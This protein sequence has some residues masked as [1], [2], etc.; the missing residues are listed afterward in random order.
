M[1][2]YIEKN[3][4]SVYSDS[5]QLVYS[6]PIKTHK[7]YIYF[8]TNINKKFVDLL[9]KSAPSGSVL[10]CDYDHSFVNFGFKNPQICPSGI[11]LYLEQQDQDDND[12]EHIMREY[13]FLATQ[14]S[15]DHCEIILKIKERAL[16]KLKRII[17]EN[18]DE[19]KEIFGSFKIVEN[20][21][22]NGN[23]VHTLDIIDS[24]LKSGSTDD[25][26]ASPTV[27][28]F[29]THPVS[30]YKMYKVKYGPPSVQDY[31]SI[32]TLCKKHN[33]VVHFVAS[34]EGIYVVYLLPSVNGAEKTIINKIEKHF[35]YNDKKMDLYKYIDQINALNIFSVSLRPWKDTDLREGLRIHFRKS[36]EW[37]NCKIRD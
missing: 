35:K 29:H 21:K 25:V 3:I 4:F 18:N 1:R 2:G 22:H 28:N 12:S 23:I 8:D 32:Y 37:G 7:N 6:T 24:S 30:A 11:C 19:T 15:N 27:Y 17:S 26:T 16:E 20:S 9:K 33:C 5:N 10:V 14:L 36:G 34:I 13:E 31:T